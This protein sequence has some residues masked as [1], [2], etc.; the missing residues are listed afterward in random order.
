MEHH[1]GLDVSLEETSV[2]IVDGAGKI[3]RE[4]QV[5]S[6]PEALVGY[7]SALEIKVVCIGLEAGPLSQ[8]LHAALT[9]AG[10]EVVLL[11]T[12]HV[13]AALSAMTVKTD[14]RDARGIA[15]LL[16]MGW[17]R[18]VHCK[19]LPSQEVRAI[20]TA[21]KTLLGNLIDF[22]LSMRGILRGFGLKVGAVTRKSFEIRVRELMEGQLTLTA[23][24]EGMLNSRATLITEVSKL[25]KAILRIARADGVC[26][27]LMTAPGVGALTALI[28]KTAID[29]P[30]RIAK[31]RDVGPLFAPCTARSGPV[32][33]TS[34]SCAS[35]SAERRGR[36][37]FD[38][39][40][41]S[42]SGPRSLKRCTQSRSVWR[43]MPPIRAASARLIPSSTAASDSRR[44][45][46]LACLEAAARRRSSSAEKFALT[47]TAVA[48]ARILPRHGISS[49]SRRESPTSQNGRPVVSEAVWLGVYFG[50]LLRTS[51]LVT[52]NER[53]GSP[54]QGWVLRPAISFAWQS[55]AGWWASPRFVECDIPC[56]FWRKRNGVASRGGS[57]RWGLR[58]AVMALLGLA[59]TWALNEFRT[60]E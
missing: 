39:L 21:R 57:R 52:P 23:I 40:S 43:S 13:K 35:C 47:V 12:R 4:T 38:Q 54:C 31:S 49:T 32:S 53:R 22:E 6:E 25:H 51:S 55:W 19:T 60:R 56:A 8:W 42:P 59:G 45:L 33:T 17:Y 36:W 27:R 37:P 5:A 30:T 29:D 20:I 2:C 14:R 50:T 24:M 28:F 48:M 15:Q 58:L 26:V 3:I 18:P 11:E 1:A 9:E 41:L 44:R 7:F 10:F 46:W 34:A 16:R